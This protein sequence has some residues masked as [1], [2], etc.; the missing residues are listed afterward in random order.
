MKRIPPMRSTLVPQQTSIEPHYQKWL[1]NYARDQDILIK[2]LWERAINELLDSR[3]A[4]VEEGLIPRYA[5]RS[6][7]K[8]VP[9]SVKLPHPIVNRVKA[10]AAE[11]S[12]SVRI[13]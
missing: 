1:I 7:D 4:V 12:A 9:W 8:Q 13:F 11:D 3:A 2:D 10:S 6:Q 5:A